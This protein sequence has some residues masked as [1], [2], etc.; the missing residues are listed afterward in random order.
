M[1]QGMT[2]T[3]KLLIGLEDIAEKNETIVSYINLY[4][5]LP[6]KKGITYEEDGETYIYLQKDMEERTEVMV[7]AEETGHV[8]K[9]ICHAWTLPGLARLYEEQ[10]RD[11]SAMYRVP[12][13]EYKLA[14]LDPHIKSD[15]DMAEA[16]EVEVD[17][18]ERARRRYIAMGM[19]VWRSD[20]LW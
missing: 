7:F 16:L 19:D 4:E 10:A 3:Y 14:M 6:D 9:G 5:K 17:A 11:W 20:E 15:Y 1:S 12:H 18:I 2:R 13:R 8:Y